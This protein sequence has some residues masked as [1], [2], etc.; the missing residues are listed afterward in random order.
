VRR[1]ST[2]QAVSESNNNVGFSIDNLAEAIREAV[3]ATPASEP[4]KYSIALST[5]TKDEDL[6]QQERDDAFEIF[7]NNPWVADTYVRIPDASA[8]NRFLR[9]RLDEFQIEKF[10]GIRN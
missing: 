2:G 8:R 3:T 6:S 7:M 10:D 5:V 1:I 4:D 9:K